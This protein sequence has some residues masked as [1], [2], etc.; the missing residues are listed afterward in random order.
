MKTAA[1]AEGGCDLRTKA[2]LLLGITSHLFLFYVAG[3]YSLAV[4]PWP[5]FAVIA[6]LDVA[7]GGV[8]IRIH[9]ADAHLAAIVASLLILVRWMV[10]AGVASWPTVAMLAAGALVAFACLWVFLAVR[11]GIGD[12][13]FA[14]AAVCGAFL[15]QMLAIIASEESGAPDVLFLMA[16]HVVL[17]AVLL[18]I[19]WQRRWHFLTVLAV[20]PAALAQFFWQAGHR[21]GA[22]WSECLLFAS[23]IYLVF[24]A[25]PLIL[26]RRAVRLLEP[27]LAAV[28]ASA[29]FFLV[30]RRSLL[31]VGFDA[32]IG[33]LP[34]AQAGLAAVHL[35][36][37]LRLE[38][39]GA[40]LGSRLA[41]VA[42]TVLAF[43]TVAIPLQL[44]KEWITV[45]WALEGAALA[46]LYT[47]I[48]HRGLLTASGLLLAAVFVRLGLNS[49][50]LTYH[51]RGVPILNW[52][53]YTYLVSSSAM[54]VAGRLLSRTH[55]VLIERVP[56]IS[57]LL[58]A[59]GTVLLFLLVNI[60]I[61]DF[62]SQGETIAFNFSATLAQDLT[63]TLAWG[64]FA[65]GLLAAGIRFRNRPA[66]SAA[67]ALLVATIL[68]CFLHDLSRLG[69][70]YRVG[71]FVGLAVCLALVAIV[72]Q[73][74]VLGAKSP[75]GG[76]GQ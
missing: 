26:G 13:R 29:V 74:Y 68:K 43:V 18:T 41:L 47:R 70:L 62:Y 14:V 9:R 37:V 34:L 35:R 21:G 27:Y 52:Y 65:L 56:R 69:G 10:T 20:L 76:S 8:A 57:S 6:V 16:S 2:Y 59:A 33:V 7:I 19:S 31:D 51:P 5:M 46:W 63:Y 17:L 23:P 64:L 48:P 50:V 11:A 67:I 22:F 73:K 39:P 72:L 38:P 55:D 32:I 3:S 45:G 28:F 61:A 30:A 60:E 71:S 25:Y 15:T 24:F 53:L 12:A 66:R 36:Q 75:S 58:A 1:G 40:R 42:G 4:P 54:L 49:Q 44:E